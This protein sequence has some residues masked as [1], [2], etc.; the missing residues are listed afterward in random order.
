M[1]R[2]HRRAST[3]LA[4]AVVAGLL[5]A[6]APG[7]GA[8]ADGAPSSSRPSSSAPAAIPP[9][10]RTSVLGP[11]Y[12][13]SDDQVL[14]VVGDAS[15][16]HLLLARERDGYA[17]RTVTTLS[18][19][20][21]E[22]D[23]WIGNTCLTAD[24]EHAA[25]VYAPRTATNRADL[26]QRGGLAAVVDLRSGRVRK[27]GF[28]ST[29]AYYN[30]GCGVGRSAVF[31]RYVGLEQGPDAVR[32]R[33]DVVDT[34]TGRTTRASTVTGQ[35]ASA[36][37]TRDTVVSVLGRSLVSVD[38]RGT[39]ARLAR[40]SS[41]AD[42][43]AVGARGSVTFV[44]RSGRSAAVRSLGLRSGRTATIA[45]R[46]LAD[47][48]DQSS[49][50]GHA[51]VVDAIPA[52]SQTDPITIGLRVVKTGRDVAL[53]VKP[54][55][56]PLD[57]TGTGAAPRPA[58]AAA[59]SS[60]R[61][62]T[63]TV[64]R[65]ALCAVPRNDPR[66]Q[67]YQPTPRQV[68]W[69]VDR[70]V[71]GTL[72]TKRAAGWKS[73]R[74]S[75]SWSP[76]G[77][78]PRRPLDGGGRVPAQVL[79]GILAQE[80]NLWQAGGRSL[81]GIPGNPLVGNFYGI[82]QTSDR[83][84]DFTIDWDRS[85]CG[86]GVAQVTDGMRKGDARGAFQ[87]RAIA[88]DYATNIA[89]GLDVLVQKWNQTR[90]AGVV[91]DDGDPADLENWVF[92]LW[93]YN[94][95]FHDRAGNGEPW[96]VGWVNNP[97]NTIWDPARGPY[98]RDPA[99]ATHPQDWPYQEKVMGY[100]AYSITTP[101]GPGFLPA[102]WA[103]AAD[104][105]G[106]KPPIGTFCRPEVNDCDLSRDFGASNHCGHK[107]AAGAYDFVCWWNQPF[108]YQ[109]CSSGHCGQEAL[110]FAADAPEPADGTNRRPVCTRKGL[111]SGSLVVDDVPGTVAP[112]STRARPCGATARSKGSFSLSLPEQSAG[113]SGARIDL[114]QSGVG[115]G[116]HVW[117]AHT[118]KAPRY[119]VDLTITGTWRFSST[120]RRR[121]R[122]LVHVP[123]YAA[124]TRE[125]RYV[126][127]NGAG[128]KSARTIR[129]DRH[130]N[131]WVSLGV[132]TFRGRPTISLSSRTPR[133]TGDA[134]I[135]WDAVAIQPLPR[136]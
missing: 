99:D 36:V 115:F 72:T 75:S 76:Q 104:R 86:Y 23:R 74:M 60:S 113:K 95:G 24:G 129:Q 35:L 92:A 117:W 67:V 105:D 131:A 94:S 51:V 17:W 28:G 63:V 29:L 88:L 47:R 90:A 136:K 9:A 107:N 14:K 102:R 126:I 44:E 22:T 12:R 81:P 87:Q 80:S 121:A 100:A 122:V 15:G 97:A 32:T 11:G 27:L 135:A 118:W 64:D 112:V 48:G 77:L 57:V 70:A 128:K 132:Y 6:A 96:G 10:E 33:L 39:L 89:A 91:H 62:S 59:A 85:D 8:T 116:G 61:R 55:Q 50:R 5:V 52:S 49:S 4:A 101:D 3:G 127:T 34:G 54:G 93:A 108:S 83:S 30:P 56:D 31:S 42:H 98:L 7:P 106:A 18:E 84:D 43:L 1:A 134:A 46:A 19:P 26:L 16:L 13:S 78:I 71:A 38:R 41:P 25:V 68:E 73:A 109:A 40:T 66:T 111:P 130:R 114:H 110:R 65:D 125:A 45:R 58:R 119:G 20:G 53:S 69:A 21:V 120:I 103:T 82:A 133:G 79:L 124:T 37:P 123:D 2:T